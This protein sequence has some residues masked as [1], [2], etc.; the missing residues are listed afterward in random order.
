[1]RRIGV[2]A[3]I[4]LAGGLWAVTATAATNDVTHQ[5]PAPTS[6]DHAPFCDLPDLPDL[7]DAPAPAP[8]G[9]GETLVS[10]TILPRGC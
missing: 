10:F 3:A 5:R 9:A 2:L 7:P 4:V 1:M 6:V 8:P